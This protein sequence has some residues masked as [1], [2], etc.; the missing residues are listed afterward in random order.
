MAGA[1]WAAALHDPDPRARAIAVFNLGNIGP[2]DRAVLPALIGAL[3]DADARVRREAILALLKCGPE[4]QEAIPELTTVGA[5]DRDANV[6]DY[7]TKALA[8][9]QEGK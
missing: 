5:K 3:H 1:K 8:K 6:R 4:A 7:A 2:S 9:L